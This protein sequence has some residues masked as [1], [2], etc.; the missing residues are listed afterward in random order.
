MYY[1]EDRV[2]FDKPDEEKKDTTASKDKEEKK[3]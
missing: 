2:P 1:D 3:K